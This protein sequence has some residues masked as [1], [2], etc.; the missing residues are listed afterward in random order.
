MALLKYKGTAIVAVPLGSVALF[1][2]YQ[3]QRNKCHTSGTFSQPHVLNWDNSAY[4]VCLLA[5]K[6]TRTRSTSILVLAR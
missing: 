3:V 6:T 1:L 4:S 2:L 5:R